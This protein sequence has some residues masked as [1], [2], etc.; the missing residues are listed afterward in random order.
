MLTHRFFF[1]YKRAR[2][3][4][5]SFLSFL[6]SGSSS[7]VLSGRRPSNATVWPRHPA[8]TQPLWHGEPFLICTRDVCITPK[9]NS[10]P[11]YKC[12]TVSLAHLNCSTLVAWLHHVRSLTSWPSTWA[13]RRTPQVHQQ[14]HYLKF[15]TV[16]LL[17]IF[18]EV[19]SMY[20]NFAR[21]G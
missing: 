1:R 2:V 14:I 17:V 19:R 3:C 7:S 5:V 18:K 12:K 13:Y 21:H 15:F 8:K 6:S 9:N 10:F 20:F 11:L 4:F 16:Q